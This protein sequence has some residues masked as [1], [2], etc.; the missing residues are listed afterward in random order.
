[1]KIPVQKHIL[2]ISILAVT[3][4][5]AGRFHFPL[6]VGPLIVLGNPRD[7]SP[8]DGTTHTNPHPSCHPCRHHR[9]PRRH[10]SSHPCP[11]RLVPASHQGLSDDLQLVVAGLDLAEELLVPPLLVGQLHC[12]LNNPLALAYPSVA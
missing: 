12:D 6:L 1:M 10:P 5:Y 8:S 9:R 2:S 11:G 7:D 3:A 4:E